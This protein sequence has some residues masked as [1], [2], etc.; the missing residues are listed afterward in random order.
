MH[1]NISKIDAVNRTL[2]EFTPS[3]LRHEDRA[4]YDPRSLLLG[5]SSPGLR[6]DRS[7]RTDRV[8][9]TQQKTVAVGSFGICAKWPPLEKRESFEV[10]KSD[11]L[12]MQNS[13]AG[14]ERL[15]ICYAIE[16]DIVGL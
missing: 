2:L 8:Q 10:P 14:V 12:N 6:H 1:C 11:A 4:I 9:P 3:A 16:P 13:A 7:R 5:Q 15:Q